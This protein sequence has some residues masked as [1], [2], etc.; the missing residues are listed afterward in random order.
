[1]TGQTAVEYMARAVTLARRGWYGTPPN[2]RVGCVL[3]RAGEII[4]EGWHRQA[5]GAHAEVDALGDAE[6][7]VGGAA[8]STAYVTLM[9]CCHQGRTPPCTQALIDAGVTRVVVGMHDPNPEAGRHS[10]AELQAAGLKVVVGVLEADCRGLN[11]GFIARMTGPRPRVRIKLAMSLDGRT[12]GA[13]GHSQWIT[14]PAAREDVHRL[15][16]E[17]GAV[18]T[19]IGTALADDPSLTV[20]LD[21]DWR[22][23]LRVVL[24]SRLR[25]SPS[26][27]MLSQPGPVL[28]M[29]AAEADARWQALRDAGAQLSRVASSDNGLDLRQVLKVLAD[30]SVNDVLVEAGP[31]LAG[32]LVAAGL[33]DELVVYLAPVLIGDAGRGLIRIPGL[34]RFSD[35]LPLRLVDMRAVGDDWRLTVCCSA[36]EPR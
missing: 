2:P 29:T 31:T 8:G 17:S 36:E 28:I 22:Q 14:G 26:A 15:R 30:R 6:R 18:M 24:D 1:M 12:A 20:R 25:L 4:G 10:V 23:P 21:G 13:D 3:V 7:R 11:P 9:P 35:R 19:G 27:L 34:R 5:G 16:A 33:A 32:A